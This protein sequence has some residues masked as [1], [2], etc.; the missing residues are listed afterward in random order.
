[1]LQF[2]AVNHFCAGRTDGS[3]FSVISIEIIFQSVHSDQVSWDSDRTV[4]S[5]AALCA[6]FRAH[7]ITA[8]F[9]GSRHLVTMSAIL[10]AKWQF[11]RT[12]SHTST[13]D[14]NESPLLASLAGYSLGKCVAARSNIYRMNCDQRDTKL[15]ETKLG[16]KNIKQHDILYWRY[17]FTHISAAE[18]D[19]IRNLRVSLRQKPHKTTEKR[20]LRWETC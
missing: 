19:E 16:N 2:H 5:K 6:T 18:R 1:M 10:C 14:S 12:F 7:V 17:Q 13:E 3:C 9:L 4:S 20:F 11:S 8:G 15:A